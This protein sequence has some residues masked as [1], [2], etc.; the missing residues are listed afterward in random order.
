MKGVFPR[1]TSIQNFPY[2]LHG[3]I[4]RLLISFME[5]ED[6]IGSAVHWMTRLQ[7]RSFQCWRRGLKNRAQFCR[8]EHKQ[9]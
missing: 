4:W 7:F 3:G 6:W 2:G 9:K 5:I 1:L 8:D